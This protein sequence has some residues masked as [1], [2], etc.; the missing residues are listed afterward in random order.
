MR[1]EQL[2]QDRIQEFIDYCKRYRADFDSTFIHDEDLKR[3]KVHSE[4]P[5]YILLDDKNNI[6]GTVSLIINSYFKKGKR[7]RF[8]IF[9]AVEPKS[10]WYKLMLESIL[11]HTHELNKIYLHVP[12]ENVEIAKVLQ[13]LSFNIERYSFG[14]VR[15]E[16]DIPE[17]SF[18]QDFRI[19]TFE[20]GKDEAAW[21][22]VINLAFANI[23]GS[24]IQRT[25]EMINMEEDDGHL[26]D[27]AMILYHK[28]IPIG[29]IRVTSELE[30]EITYA[31]I[32]SLCVKPEYQ[33]MGLGRSLLRSALRYGRSKGMPRAMLSVNAENDKALELYIKEGFRRDY[34]SVCY[35]YDLCNSKN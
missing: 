14:L 10:D 5:T 30:N 28:E 19:G 12:G 7:G 32:S 35:Q 25:P 20:A 4:N 1:I 13:S 27:G 26:E 9:H 34:T 16:L 21:C 2:K 29:T 6:N 22:E 31:F 3:F 18:S 24:D 23:S 15:D 8:R 17:V 33:G 11:K